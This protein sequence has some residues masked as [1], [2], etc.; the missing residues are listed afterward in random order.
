MTPL[1]WARLRAQAVDAACLFVFAVLWAY[2]VVAGVR[3]AVG[4]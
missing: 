1:Q 2:A 4:P 3:W